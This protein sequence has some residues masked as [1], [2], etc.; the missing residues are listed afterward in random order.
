[1]TIP[2]LLAAAILVST[3]QAAY[4]QDS[5]FGHDASDTFP[6]VC[7]SAAAT[8]PAAHSEAEM[9]AMQEHQRAAM[10]GMMK[11]DRDMSEGMMQDDADVAFIC[12]MIAHHHGAIDMARVE[13]QYGNDAWAKQMAEK[14]IEAQTKEIAEMTDWLKTNAK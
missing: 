3:I 1:M 10:A 6:E 14:V 9:A 7:R 12:G 11:M 5:H 8:P 4:A 13:L 2:R